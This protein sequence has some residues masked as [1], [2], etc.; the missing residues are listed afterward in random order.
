MAVDRDCRV[1]DQL[2]SSSE[3]LHSDLGCIASDV[4]LQRSHE[5]ARA[6]R[7]PLSAVGSNALLCGNFDVTRGLEPCL[8]QDARPMLSGRSAM[9]HLHLPPTFPRHSDCGCERRASNARFTRRLKPAMSDDQRMMNWSRV[10]GD[11]G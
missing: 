9:A 7:I 4:L 10:A 3:S 5:I 2:L 8:R 6:A 1:R 11:V